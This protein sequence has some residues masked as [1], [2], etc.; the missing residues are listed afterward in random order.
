M[1][2]S[3]LTKISKNAKITLCLI[4]TTPL[5]FTNSAH[6]LNISEFFDDIRSEVEGYANTFFYKAEEE[7]NAKWE[8]IKEDARS[9]INSS[10]GNMGLPNSI[11]A[12]EELKE[13]I[14]DKQTIA[15][16]AIR[17]E[18]LERALNRQ[19]VEAV[20]GEEGQTL[21]KNSIEDTEEIATKSFESAQKTDSL[22]QTA[23]GAR[24]SQDVLKSISAQQ[25]ALSE[26]NSQITWLLS[27]QRSD[28]LKNQLTQTQG[29][30][31]LG[32]IAENQAAEA[33]GK[34][35]QLNANTAT[36]A[37]MATMLQLDVSSKYE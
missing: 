19:S 35:V 12:S 13:E 37:E 4:C 33:R 17:A 18:E 3:K 9:A 31:M 1:K 8:G 25:A 34:Q 32:Q 10:V 27:K 5:L 20:I 6:A 11:K 26:Q 15:Q 23:Q 7:I 30:L 22:A 28:S 24:S 21:T 14:G 29:N 36:I 16:K 2:I